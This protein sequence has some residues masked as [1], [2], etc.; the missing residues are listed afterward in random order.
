MAG[1]FGVPENKTRLQILDAGAG[2]GVLSIAL[3]ER[4]Q[5]IP[6]LQYVHLVCY[7]NDSKIIELLRKIYN[8]L[9][10]ILHYHLITRFGK[11]TIS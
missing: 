2:S 6:K 10:S 8:G 9:G 5:E 11:I 7:E 1:L 3:I 4:L